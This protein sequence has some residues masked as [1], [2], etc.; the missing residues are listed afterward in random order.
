MKLPDFLHEPEPGEIVLTGHRIGLYTIVRDYNE[1]LAPE[2]LH[3][4]YPT[5]PLE[6]IQKVLEFYRQNNA[7]V[8]TYVAN[9]R[10][11]LERQ[12]KAGS[13]VDLD[14][15]RKRFAQLYPGQPIPGTEG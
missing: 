5:L 8:D 10:A 12:E 9:Y 15:L 1:G 14:K 4:E 6:L 13:H 3:E 11:E 2:M 7:E